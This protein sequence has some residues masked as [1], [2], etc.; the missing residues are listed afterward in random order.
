MLNKYEIQ[1]EFAREADL[2]YLDGTEIG[3]HHP[4][5]FQIPSN[6]E[7]AKIV[8]G[9]YVKV[10]IRQGDTSKIEYAW[11]L[12]ISINGDEIT[13]EVDAPLNRVKLEAGDEIIFP[14]KAVVGIMN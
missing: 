6:E 2:Y 10:G 11:I 9:Y 8:P 4:I 12:V 3:V 5:S 14:M 13:G 7:K 1:N